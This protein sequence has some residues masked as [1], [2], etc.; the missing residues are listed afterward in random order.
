[1][2]YI[3]PLILL[4]LIGPRV[5]AQRP[6]LSAIQNWGYQLQD[7]MPDEVA[8]NPSFQLIVM[9]YSNDGT[10]DTKFTPSEISAIK[11]SGKR[12]IAYFSIGEAEDYRFYWKPEW[13]STPPAWLGPENPDWPGNYKV[14][15]WDPDWRNIVF[16]YLDKII[17]QGFDGIYLDIIDGFDYWMHDN[18]EQPNADTL[19]VDFVRSIRTY[20]DAHAPGA[21]YILP[22]NP[23]DI[24]H[25][26]NITPAMRDNFFDAIDAVGV[27]DVFFPGDL[28]ENNPFAPNTERI[29]HLQEFR[30]AGIPVFSIEYLTQQQKKNQYLAAVRNAGFIPYICTRELD[31]LCDGIATSISHTL[32]VPAELVTMQISPQPMRN[33]GLIRLTCAIRSGISISLFDAAGRYIKALFSGELAPGETAIPL[34]LFALPSGTYLVS[35]RAGDYTTST[36][37]KI[38]R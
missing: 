34:D 7:I 14:R 26:T 38:V 21:F 16:G 18:P 20:A 6:S 31:A 29:A 5:L 1:M 27:E 4:L 24:L 2:K 15:F 11:L 10:E 28:A 13:S 12:A 9:D 23:D 22:Q 35:T 32:P 19:M 8:S 30:N 3:V 36:P 37:L 33:A 25:S 17:A